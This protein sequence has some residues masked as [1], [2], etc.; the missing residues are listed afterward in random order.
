MSFVVFVVIIYIIYNYIDVERCKKKRERKK[1]PITPN[2]LR[3]WPR[4]WPN[5]LI[6]LGS[7]DGN[8]ARRGGTP[9]NLRP[10]WPRGWPTCLISLG[11]TDGNN[12]RR[13]WTVPGGGDA[14]DGPGVGL[15]VSFV[16]VEVGLCHD[17]DGVG[18]GGDEGSSISTSFSRPIP[19]GLSSL[20]TLLS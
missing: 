5:C 2:N 20:I 13:G 19:L 3:P 11:S 12:A 18:A 6:S 8:N 15:A 10:P 17:V 14:D 4:G 1:L 7:T 9:Y 16:L